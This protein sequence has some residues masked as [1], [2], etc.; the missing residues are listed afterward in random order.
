[1]PRS[2]SLWVAL[3]LTRRVSP[4]PCTTLPAFRVLY[5]GGFL[6]GAFPR[7]SPLPWAFAFWDQ[8]RLPL[9]LCM[10]RSL[11]ARQTSRYAADCRFAQPPFRP[12]SAG[13]DAGLSAGPGRS[14]GLRRRSATRR[15]GPY[16]D[17]TLTGKPCT[18][19]LDA[20]PKL[21]NTRILSSAA[22]ARLAWLP[23]AH[24]G[25]GCRRASALGR[26]SQPYEWAGPALH[27]PKKPS[28]HSW[29]NAAHTSVSARRDLPMITPRPVAGLDD[30]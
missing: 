9:A 27:L 18:A 29:H 13:F 8:T 10:Q 1:M 16:R 19:Y 17:R 25:R 28:D 4:V 7:S 21:L 30:P 22:A 11:T 26:T 6:V 12:L 24:H 3:A 14:L 15:L 5:A 20:L 2:D 23:R